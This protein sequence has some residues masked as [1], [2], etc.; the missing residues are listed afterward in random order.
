MAVRAPEFMG[1]DIETTKRQFGGYRLTLGSGATAV[2]LDDNT[3]KRVLQNREPRASERLVLFLSHEE[4][5]EFDRWFLED[6]ERSGSFL[7]EPQ[8]N[9]DPLGSKYVLGRIREGSI[10]GK[11]VV[12]QELKGEHV[13]EV[14]I[15]VEFPSHRAIHALPSIYE[16]LPNDITFTELLHIPRDS[17]SVNWREANGREDWRGTIEAANPFQG[18]TQI[19]FQNPTFL[20]PEINAESMMVIR[21]SSPIIIEGFGYDTADGRVTSGRYTFGTRGFI[22]YRPEGASYVSFFVPGT[23]VTADAFLEP[24]ETW[25][26]RGLTQ[27]DDTDPTR[28]GLNSDRL[29]MQETRNPSILNNIALIRS[30]PFLLQGFD[31][32]LLN[33]ALSLVE[34]R[35]FLDKQEAIA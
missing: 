33:R 6:I 8:L 20:I 15:E 4:K 7:Y 11:R 3:Y 28:V 25:A 27:V 16:A 35:D 31:I 13:W 32:I 24:R 29:G 17:R 9:P 19:V 34:I 23:Q 1:T 14:E 5:R 2:R 26:R 21:Y 18:T 12:Q 30:T 22:F 10:R